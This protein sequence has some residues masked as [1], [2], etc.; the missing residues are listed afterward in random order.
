MTSST[1]SPGEVKQVVE[2]GNKGLGD[3]GTG[4]DQMP[5]QKLMI[6]FMKQHSS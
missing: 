6:Y 5:R 4:G 3:G 1:A 2:E